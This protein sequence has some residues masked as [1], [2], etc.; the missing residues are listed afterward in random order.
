MNQSGLW[1]SYSGSARIA[2]AVILLAA[3]GGLA[4]GGTRLR[5]PVRLRQPGPGG[6]IF[7]LVAWGLALIAFLACA[8]VYVQQVRRDH[9]THVAAAD[10]ITPVTIIA[11][12]VLFLIVFVATPRGPWVRLTSAAIAA[13]TAPMIFELP[14][15]LIVMARTNPPVPPDPAFY[16]ALFFVPLIL[17]E[18]TTLS[19][20][21]LTPMVRLF[22]PACY[23]LALMLLVFAVWALAGF[24]Y[25]SET[26]PIALNVVSKLLAF[27]TALSLFVPEWFTLRAS[28]LRRDRF[29]AAPDA[30]RG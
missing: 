29:A 21:T 30:A 25:P 1:L 14:F 6:T 11:A 27:V 12:V 2:L 5:R 23:W 8:S 13:M 10:P 22:R 3:A 4:Y 26:V 17:V 18:L 16:R 15:D 9:I 28:A 19:L 20:L 24:G 7:L